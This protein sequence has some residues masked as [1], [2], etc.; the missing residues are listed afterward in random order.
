[1]LPNSVKKSKVKKEWELIQAGLHDK[2]VFSL[3]SFYRTGVLL[4]GVLAD[5]SRSI[6]PKIM[7]NYQKLHGSSFA[8][9]LF[10]LLLSFLV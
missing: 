7:K 3:Y 6:L 4:Q 2:I 9:P 10:S 1:M 8:F 5:G